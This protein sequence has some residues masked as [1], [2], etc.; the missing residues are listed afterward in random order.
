MVK[1]YCITAPLDYTTENTYNIPGNANR[2]VT[3]NDG[4]AMTAANLK[5]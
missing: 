1:H 5:T 4:T 2:L 3:A